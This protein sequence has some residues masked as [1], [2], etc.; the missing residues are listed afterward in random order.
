MIDAQMVFPHNV[1][2][3]TAAAFDGID[4]DVEVLRRPLR[5][6]DPQQSVGVHSQIWDPQQDS[7]EMGGPAGPVRPTLQRYYYGAQAFVRDAD[8]ER[9]LAV[10]ATLA[11]RVKA[12]LYTHPGLRVALPGLRVDYVDG[13]A[14]VLQR[15]GITNARYL[16]GEIEGVNLYLST[17]EFWVETETR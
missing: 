7:Q 10:H 5:N 11:D 6:T 9:A 12:V 14:E 8:E 16:S 2:V 17:L 1:V 15:W 13:S 4:P 3:L